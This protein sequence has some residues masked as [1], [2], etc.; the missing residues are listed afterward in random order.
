M[1]IAELIRYL[2][3]T[4]HP[5]YQEDY[6][7]AGFLVGDGNGEVC[8]VLVALDLTPSVVDEA[9]QKRANVIVTHHPFI[10]GGIKRITTQNQTGRMV[11]RLIEN[12]IAVYAAHTNL[13]N[14]IEGVNGALAQQLGIADCHILHPLERVGNEWVGAGLWGTLTSPMPTADFLAMVKQRL[15]LPTIRCSEVCR[16]EVQRIAICGGAGSFLIDDAIRQHSDIFL[17]GDLKY[18]DF[19]RAEGRIVIADIGHYESEQFALKT[20]CCAIS[21]KN[22]TFVCQISDIRQGYV[23]YM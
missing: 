18:H 14:M 17:T 8:G 21:E 20:I 9:L 13:D 16:G 7:N 1:K 4:F 23:R 12:H 3:D 15:H 10:F 2:D 22:S 5:E 6:D 19:Q 11:I